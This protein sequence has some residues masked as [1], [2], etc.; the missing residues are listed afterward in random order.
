MYRII[1]RVAWQKMHRGNYYWLSAV[2]IAG[3][4]CAGAKGISWQQEQDR[5]NSRKIIRSSSAAASCRYRRGQ[6]VIQSLTITLAQTENPSGLLWQ[7]QDDDI[8]ALRR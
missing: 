1:C 7:E 8:R 6:V 4:L 2:I 3:Y 5:L